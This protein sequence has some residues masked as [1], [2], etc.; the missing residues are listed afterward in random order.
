MWYGKA[1][2]LATSCLE[3]LVQ[4]KA[5]Q[6]LFRNIPAS[7]AVSAFIGMVA[8]YCNGLTFYGD[9]DLPFEPEQAVAYFVDIFLH[10]MEIPAASPSPQ[11]P[12]A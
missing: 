2:L 12:T 9:Q 4:S 1:T 3:P 6:G 10:G 8:D 5:D 7:V 11:N